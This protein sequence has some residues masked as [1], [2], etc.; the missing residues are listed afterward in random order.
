MPQSASRIGPGS[1]PTEISGVMWP[2]RR[3]HP[4]PSPMTTRR[5]EPSGRGTWNTA[6]AKPARG[7][8]SGSPTCRVE[9]AESRS[10]PVSSFTCEPT[11]ERTWP[12]ARSH[13]RGRRENSGSVA[14]VSTPRPMRGT[15]PG[16]RC[17]RSRPINVFRTRTIPSST[18]RRCGR[19]AGL[20]RPG[21]TACTPRVIAW[22]TAEA[23]GA[24]PPE[25]AVT[26]RRGP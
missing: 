21:S 24:S 18:H 23:A 13:S 8:T 2:A 15:S 11:T 9:R 7:A 17:D 6:T 4:S 10:T 16:G 19:F 1:T 22:E 3:S 25:P 20:R 14:G 12:R 26:H 5:P